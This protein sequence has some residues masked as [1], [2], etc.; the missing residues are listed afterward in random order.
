MIADIRKLGDE[1][2]RGYSEGIGVIRVIGEIRKLGLLHCT[3]AYM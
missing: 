1:S 2:I 3:N